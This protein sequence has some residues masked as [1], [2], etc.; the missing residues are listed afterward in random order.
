[1]TRL[2]AERAGP[3]WVEC[4]PD[5]T[6]DCP[7]CQDEGCTRDWCRTCSGRGSIHLWHLFSPTY[8]VHGYSPHD[9]GLVGTVDM[10]LR[11]ETSR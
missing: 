10:I 2:L 8:N 3:G 6:M 11:L 5:E 9:F 7:E 1:M 4:D